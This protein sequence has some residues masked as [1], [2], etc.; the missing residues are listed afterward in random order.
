MFQILLLNSDEFDIIPS[1]YYKNIKNHP[2]S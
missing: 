1:P 2:K